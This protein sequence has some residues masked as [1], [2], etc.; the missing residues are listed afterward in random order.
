MSD[1]DSFID[2]VNEELKRDRLFATMRKLAPYALAG[3]L[4]LV[5]GAA[6]N[7][8]SKAKETAA[9]QAFGDSI[10]AAIENEDPEAQRAALGA[11][12][13][14]GDRQ[15][16]LDLLRAANEL[17][18]ED[19]GAA[20]ALLAGVEANTALPASYRQIAA[21]KRVIIGGAL[22]PAGERE[23]VLAGLAAAG[24]PFR[25]LALE[26]LALLALETG[27]RDAALS[28]AQSL[29]Q[30]P[31]VTDALRRRVAQLIVVLGGDLPGN[32]G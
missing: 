15:G 3:V 32:L 14:D 2:E 26:Q 19:R 9:A 20:I 11:I 23:A 8:W 4:I 10:L 16:I 24:Q 17:V 1:T 5:G 30:E 18:A 6:W 31:D 29:L 28:R 22:I 12:A 13:A 27:D 21:L 25:P 7:E